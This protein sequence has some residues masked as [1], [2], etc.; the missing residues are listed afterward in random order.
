MRRLAGVF[1]ARVVDLVVVVAGVLAAGCSST[2]RTA[3]AAREQNLEAVA[4]RGAWIDAQD[5]RK[6]IVVQD[7]E[8]V[9]ATTAPD[10]AIR[11][12]ERR[13]QAPLHRF[14]FRRGDRGERLYRMAFLPEGGI[15]AGTRFLRDLGL[16]A[17]WQ[18]GKPLVL[19]RRG[20]RREAEVG[21][22]PSLDVALETLDRET[23]IEVPVV[24]D[25]DFDGGLLLDLATAERLRLSLFE[26]PG[27]AEVNV[28]LGRPFTARRGHVLAHVQETGATAPVEV[29]WEM[30]P[31]ET[32]STGR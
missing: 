28:A 17:T 27:V 2:P 9:A 8:V 18:P 22:A 11:A 29:L 30:P 10:D 1:M 6:F 15:V 32:R 4:A 14:V 21:G 5:A 19:E 31:A 3:D 23:R 26:L 7:A 13:R 24:L 16:A 25:L 12:A 20:R